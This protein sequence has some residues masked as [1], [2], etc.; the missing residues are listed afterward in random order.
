M[1]QNRLNLDLAV[2]QLKS[3]RPDPERRQRA[4]LVIGRPRRRNYRL[5]TLAATGAAVLTSVFLA[6]PAR[7]SGL[8]WQDVRERTSRVQN[9]HTR[10]FS[11]S[12]KSIGEDWY[13]G[14]LRAVWSRDESGRLRTE[15]RS[16]STDYYH[17][18]YRDQMSGP[19]AYQYGEIWDK[20][21][22]LLKL[23]KGFSGPAQTID[24]MLGVK[25]AK[26]ISHRS[27]RVDGQ[28]FERYT[29]TRYKE[30]MTVDVNPR[31]GLIASIAYKGGAI[32]K[33]EYPTTIDPEVFSYRSRLLKSVPVLD[34]RG[35]DSTRQQPLPPVIASKGGIELRDVT[36]SPWGHLFVNWTGPVPKHRLDI[37]GVSFHKVEWFGPSI[38][39]DRKPSKL[40]LFRVRPNQRVGDSVSIRFRLEGALV[41]F[42]NVK[43]NRLKALKD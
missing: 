1:S 8:S 36:I 35:T 38:G 24:Q 22:R 19:N 33:V 11:V 14:N 31:T 21:P 7:G 15:I 18:I 17:Y 5:V 39:N 34:T 13:S 26:L 29:L 25:D 2:A 28:E 20:S 12:G 37:S 4:H 42:K 40:M 6:V 23:E 9:M 43:V 41:E 3:E 32:A 10:F 16:S 30:Q 27:M